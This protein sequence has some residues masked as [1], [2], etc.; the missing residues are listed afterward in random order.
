MHLANIHS[1]KHL[2]CAAAPIMTNK[3]SPKKR[4]KLHWRKK[5]SLIVCGDKTEQRLSS[6]CF[7]KK[8][9]RQLTLFLRRQ[10]VLK[11]MSSLKQHLLFRR[12]LR[13]LYSRGSLWAG[14]LQR[15][16]VP[17]MRRQYLLFSCR[18]SVQTEIL[19]MRIQQMVGWAARLFHS[20]WFVTLRI[21][22]SQSGHFGR[23]RSTWEDERQTFRR[24]RSALLHWRLAAQA[25]GVS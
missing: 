9:Y 7:L 11:K 4:N 23:C 6:F 19:T 21:L 12:R 20:R 24:W 8:Y 5:S 22:K 18:H 13:M 25:V 17:S 16:Q 3:T 15:Q 10:H 14:S 2:F 1:H